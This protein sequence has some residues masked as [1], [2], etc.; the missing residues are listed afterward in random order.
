M[1]HDLFSSV[2]EPKDDFKMKKG[3]LALAA[4]MMLTGSAMAQVKFGVEGG[5]NLNNLADQ[6]QNETV[7]NQ[8]KT[9]VHAG[10]VADI[11]MGHFSVSPGIRYSMKGGQEQRHY[12]GTYQGYTAAVEQKNKLTYHYVE[13]PINL[14]YKTGVQG[15]GRF[16][17]GAGPYIAYMVNAQNKYKTSYLYNVGGEA[18]QV[19]EGGG[20]QLSI[21][22]EKPEDQ[23]KALDY[24]GQ[25]FVGYQLP[26]GV[27]LKAGSQVGLANTQPKGGVGEFKQK[28]YNFFATVGYMFGGK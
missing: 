16:L 3:Y 5:V 8:I 14:V 25:A 9:G 22:D 15:A 2:C 17:I 18:K 12:N 19:D 1:W 24:G 26:M 20:M 27:F 7:S 13:V 21:G 6:Y 28:N 11:G 4:A 23:I 10:L